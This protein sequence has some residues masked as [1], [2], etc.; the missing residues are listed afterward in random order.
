VANQQSTAVTIATSAPVTI[1]NSVIESAVGI[2]PNSKLSTLVQDSVAG[3]N[4]TITHTQLFGLYPGGTNL[5]MGNAVTLSHGFASFIF[6]HNYIAQVGGIY[7]VDSNPTGSL[8]V[9]YNVAQN[10]DGRMTNGAGG[11]LTSGGV[12]MG[13]VIT[14]FIQLNNVNAPGI[15]IGWNQIQNTPNASRVEDNISIFD[16]NGTPASPIS[17][18]DN[19]ING[20]YP[21]PVTNTGYHG[22][23]IMLGDGGGSYQDAYSNQVISTT[24]Y[25]IANSGGTNTS[26]YDNTVVCSGTLANGT[27][28][29]E[30]NVGIYS[31]NE[32]PSDPYGNNSVT[33]NISGWVDS[34][35]RNDYWLPGASTASGNTDLN[36][37]KLAITTTDVNAQWTAW[38]AKLGNN[39]ITLSTGTS[40]IPQPTTTS[41]IPQPTTTSPIPQPTTTSPIPQPTTTTP[42]TRS[43]N[44]YWIA[45]S[46]GAVDPHGDAPNLGGV[47]APVL[48]APITQIVAK[49]D[50]GGYWLVAA[51]GGIFSFGDA[52]FLGSTGGMR[53]NRP[54]VGMA[55]T[56]DGGGYWLVAADGGIFS[57]G[58]AQFLGSTG[59]MRLNRPIVGMAPTPDGGGYW[60]VA[61]DGG[62]FSFGDAQFLGSTG[63]IHLNEPIVGLAGTHDGGGYWLVASDGGIFSYGDAQFLGSSGDIH[64]NEPIVGMAPTPDGG[65]YWLV[66][67]DGGIFSYG[68]ARFFGSSGLGLAP[69]VGMAT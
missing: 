56:P 39:G 63:D 60:L 66:A 51:D 50:G 16:S 54:I 12:G 36:G 10:I 48:N 52:R 65:G 9:Q 43:G 21:Y 49:P 6:Q 28:L 68:D 25:G 11:Y 7:L 38:Q 69:V 55:P 23:G 13:Y 35:G 57:F 40:P 64:L 5:W 1:T 61:S 44:G 41:P 26:I 67:S 29:P 62:I 3:V 27:A 53:L 37:N 19:Y 8:L 15:D 2:S 45:H 17:V 4:L 42:T 20:G 33:N 24:N 34:S 46:D 30:S 18:H 31:D 58:D 59:G 47:Q 14:C 32:H 22:G